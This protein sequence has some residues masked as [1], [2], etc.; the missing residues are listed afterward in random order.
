MASDPKPDYDD[1][2]APP[3]VP[4]YRPGDEDDPLVWV[5]HDVVAR[6]EGIAE[7]EEPAHGYRDDYVLIDCQACEK[8]IV[9]WGYMNPIWQDYDMHVSTTHRGTKWAEVTVVGENRFGHGER[10]AGRHFRRNVDTEHVDLLDFTILDDDHF[11]PRYEATI[12]VGRW[13]GDVDNARLERH[14]SDKIDFEA[15]DSVGVDWNH[16]LPR[17]PIDADE[18]AAVVERDRA[19]AADGG[20]N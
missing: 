7:R 1:M 5:T 18:K 2:V 4:M 13:R 10:Y 6:H 3:T 15:F 14:L 20:E 12:E 16:Q 19:V 9:G 11:R 17:E 8:V